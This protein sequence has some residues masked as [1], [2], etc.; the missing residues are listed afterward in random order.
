MFQPDDFLFWTDAIFT[1]LA[2]SGVVGPTG[3]PVS[4]T[5]ASSFVSGAGYQITQYVNSTSPDLVAVQDMT[6]L[7]AFS[8]QASQSTLSAIQNW[9][10]TT[11]GGKVDGLGHTLKDY[12][13]DGL[14]VNASYPSAQQ[15]QGFFK[16]QILA[17]MIN[18]SWRTSNVKVF[19]MFADTS[20]QDDATGPGQAKFYSPEDQGVYYLYK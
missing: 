19:I 9:A 20:S 1:T 11:F 18:M 13:A 10:T 2:S 4:A 14:F 16:Q 3:P 8:N 5:A 12:L 17:R 7:G 6:N 15:I